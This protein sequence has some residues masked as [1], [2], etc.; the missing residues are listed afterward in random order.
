MKIN[1]N[2]NILGGLPDWSLIQYY[3]ENQKSGEINN[4]GKIFSSIKTDK[5]IKRFERAIRET[6]LSFKNKNLE[7]LFDSLI[8]KEHISRDTLIFLFWNASLNNDLLHFINSS[9]FFTAF[10]AGRISIRN[11][12]VV[13]CINELRNKE[14][15]LKEWTENTIKTTASKYLTLLK[16]FGLLEGGQTKN[17]LHPFL[18]EKMFVIF[19]YWI[20]SV[21]EKSNIMNSPWLPYGFMENETFIHRLKQRQF[22]AY[23]NIYFTGDNLKIEP[24][25]KYSDIYDAITRN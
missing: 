12:E 23:F 17:I 18:S 5:S 11:D 2:I 15:E 6:F 1:T 14:L 21:S 8:T 10:F 25:L 7:C 13:A 9:V 24:I 20:V 4:N 16:K 19:V 22:A 3:Y